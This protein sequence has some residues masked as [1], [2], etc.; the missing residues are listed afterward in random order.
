MASRSILASSKYF[1]LS[2]SSSSVNSK[3]RVAVGKAFGEAEELN[4]CKD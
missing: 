4:G 1:L 3:V 2:A